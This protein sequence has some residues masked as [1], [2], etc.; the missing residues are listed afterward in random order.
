MGFRCIKLEEQSCTYI[1]CRCADRMPTELIAKYISRACDVCEE[2]CGGA[3]VC[4]EC[5]DDAQ[6][7]KAIFGRSGEP[8]APNVSECDFCDFAVCERCQ[9]IERNALLPWPGNDDEIYCTICRQARRI[10][11][12]EFELSISYKL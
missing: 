6:L 2:H 4:K 1:R 12:L 3:Y 5:S 11:E 7:R 10:R 9:S 8:R